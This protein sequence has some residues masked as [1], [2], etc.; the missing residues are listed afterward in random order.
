MKCTPW[1]AVVQ[2]LK[3]ESVDYVFG[4]PGN[5][6]H[7]IPELVSQSDIKFVLVRHEASAV[8]TAYAYAR[9]TG[10]V[11]ICFAS[12][13]PGTGNLVSGLLEATS[14]CLPIIALANGTENRTDGMGAFQE[15]DTQSLMRP[16]TKW[17]ARITD[18]AKIPWV[19]QRAF[20]L[21]VNGKPGAVFIEIPSDIG[22]TAAE[23]GPYRPHL[24][25]HRMRPDT[26]AVQAAVRLLSRS[27]RPLLLCGSG[28]VSSG[29]AEQLRALSEAGGIPVFTTPGGR[30]IISEAHDLA[31]GQVGLYFTDVGKSYYDTA[32]LIFSVG[33]RLEDF[34][35]GS[36]QFFPPDARLIQL[37]ID[38]N[39]IAMNWR[40]DA[41][42]VGDAALALADILD[43]WQPHIDHAQR[44]ARVKEIQTAKTLY[45]ESI[46]QE[47]DQKRQ[48]IR[49]PQILAAIN[50]VYG[51]N[52]ILVNENGATDLWCYF[53]PYYKVLDVGDCV[54]LAEQTSMGM[55]VVGTIGA[56][57]GRPDK[58][59]VCVTGDGALQMA[60]MELATA[61]EL[62][63]G[64][65]WV[66]L[67][68][69][70]LGWP[71][72]HQVL[73]GQPTVGTNFEVSPDFVSLAQSQGCMGIRVTDPTQVESSL[74]EALRANAKGIPV[75][76][77]CHI[78]KHDYPKHFVEINEQ[79]H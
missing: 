11:G 39:T 13:G 28:A 7:L 4:L 55:G 25:R 54:P 21:A 48:P 3:A 76:V 40:P 1:N 35:T 62:K 33:S 37:D 41:A 56:K 57:L 27:K 23:I 16:V 29:A 9:V 63:C 34:S 18:P 58:N 44:E 43:E 47:V 73:L 59:V 52:T 68:N 20:A 30:G 51:R 66:V 46:A 24:G 15:L 5:P 42:L 72:Y 77:D 71:Q 6:Q 50:K 17:A 75:L 10:K 69:Q 64:V 60:M 19:M 36:W 65:T 8:S 79:G 53:W 14:G 32:D 26:D 61:A 31:L 49:P 38:P 2:A 22:L 70:C 67:N 74:A 12:P 45:F 78:A